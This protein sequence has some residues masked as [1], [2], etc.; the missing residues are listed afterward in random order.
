MGIRG[1]KAWQPTSE[2]EAVIRAM[3]AEGHAVSAIA[4]HLNVESKTLLA[5]VHRLGLPVHRKGRR[6]G[7]TNSQIQEM[8]SGYQL[9]FSTLEI[10][11]ELGFDATTVQRYLKEAGIE[12][13]PKGFLKGEGHHGWRGGRIQTED[14]YILVLVYP[15]DP[16]YSM[17]QI[18][19]VGTSGKYVLEHRLV[20]ARHLGRVLTD[21]E[22]VHHVDDRDR[23]NNALSNLQ[24]RRGNHGTGA[25]FQCANCGSHDI[26]AV[27]LADAAL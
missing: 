23:A 2:Q 16:F 11:K 19:G 9:G 12:L 1:P 13:R 27:P 6:K 25:A 3:N 24:L 17:G 8:I 26:L 18:K 14:G 22:T 4:R 5:A 7:I 21:E 20:M 10:A 15:D